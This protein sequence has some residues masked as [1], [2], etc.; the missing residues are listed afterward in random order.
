MSITITISFPTADFDT[1]KAVFDDDASNRENA[2][3]SA[4]AYKELDDNNSVCV[5][6]TAPSREA[7]LEFFSNP[8]LQKRIK[9]VTVGPPDIKF[10]EAG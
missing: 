4:T 7:F 8:D 6:A 3:L 5:I 2:G 9:E 1:W 10:L